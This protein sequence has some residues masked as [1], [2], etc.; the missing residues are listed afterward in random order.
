MLDVMPGARLQRKRRMNEHA[1]GLLHPARV[2]Y[3]L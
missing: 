3:T 1:D 2:C